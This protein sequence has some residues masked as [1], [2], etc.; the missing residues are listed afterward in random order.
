MRGD[1]VGYGIGESGVSISIGRLSSTRAIAKVFE[2][3]TI[4]YAVLVS[5]SPAR[6]SVVTSLL[7]E[8]RHQLHQRAAPTQ[9]LKELS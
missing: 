8:I 2:A 5:S 3:S 1:A 7:R 4:L 9:V 6:C